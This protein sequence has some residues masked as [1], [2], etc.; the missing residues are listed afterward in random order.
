MKHLVLA[1]LALVSVPSVASA[2]HA[3]QGAVTQLY[4]TKA[5]AEK[6]ASAF[7]CTGAHPMGDKWMP[8]A[9][10][11]EAQPHAH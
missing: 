6:A 7:H 5:E 10:H 11:G 9:K 1:A 3:T 2:Q 8:C 4:A